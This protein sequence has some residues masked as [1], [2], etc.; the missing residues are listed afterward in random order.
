MR[1]R[2]SRSRRMLEYPQ[3]EASQGLASLLPEI[4]DKLTP[5]GK[6]PESDMISQGFTML[7]N[8]FFGS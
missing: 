8:K 4:I 1:I 5:D 3:E 6:V 7:K 2:Y